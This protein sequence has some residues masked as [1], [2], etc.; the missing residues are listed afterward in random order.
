[1]SARGGWMQM[2]TLVLGFNLGL[3]M[4]IPY[5]RAEDGIRIVALG[6]SLTAG[7]ML[8]PNA[9]FPAQLQQALRAKGHVVEVINAG[10]SGDTT[11]AGL[12]RFDWAFGDRFDAAIVE[13]GANDA[14]R[15]LPP[16]EARRNLDEILRRLAER[17]K[18][19]LI[20]GMLSPQNWGA[21][22]VGQFNAIFP[23]LAKTY[24]SPLYPFFLDGVTLVPG[25][26][27]PDGLHPN[28]K[29]VAEIVRRILPSVE[30]L[31]DRAKTQRAAAK[32]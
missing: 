16:A 3:A 18:P 14:L 31:I 1:M 10:V 4:A 2:V 32:S 8:P 24:D 6:D 11:A 30:A 7:Y 23:E 5:V 26:T 9:S 27:L 13:L 21:D 28:E 17:R 22:Y 25:M 12:A 19:V 20:A 15:G 29:G